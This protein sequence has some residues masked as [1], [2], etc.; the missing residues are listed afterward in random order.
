L[1]LA[2]LLLVYSLPYV[3]FSNM[4][5]VIGHK[6]W[7]TRVLSVFTAR[8]DELLFAINPGDEQRLVQV[9]DQIKAA[10]CDEVGLS[11]SRNNLEYQLWYLLGAPESR[12]EIQHLTSLAEFSQYLEPDYQPCAVVC[13]LCDALPEGYRLPQSYDFGA[14]RLYLDPGS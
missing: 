14:I 9:A 4:R 11:Y 2:G 10:N 13:T 5:P 12:I 3:L 7:P 6:P 8:K 1:A